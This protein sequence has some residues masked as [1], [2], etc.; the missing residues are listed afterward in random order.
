MT[1]R[2]ARRAVLIAAACLVPAAGG[3]AEYPWHGASKT[4]ILARGDAAP[5]PFAHRIAAFAKDLPADHK[6]KVVIGSFYRGQVGMQQ[7][8][9]SLTPLDS[10]GRP[11]GEELQF[12]PLWGH[13]IHSVTYRKGVKHGPEKAYRDSPRA[14]GRRYVYKLTPWKDGKIHGVVRLSYPTGEAM[15]ET[16]HANGKREGVSRSFEPDGFM[17]RSV[18][19]KNDQRCGEAV[20]YWPTTKKL[21]KVITYKDG[22]SHG[23]ARQ[24]YDSG[25]LKMEVPLWEDEFHGVQKHYDEDGKLRKT[26]YWILDEEVSE[27]QFEKR[28]RVPPIPTTR[29]A[30]TTQKSA[31]TKPVKD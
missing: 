17:K 9:K 7:Q 2:P 1:D 11:D 12:G 20:E 31:E 13:P 26:T 22:L 6:V 4:L 30:P 21:K 18:T 16:P 24:Y 23:P 29:K 15:M 3:L 27:E 5:E 19:Y 14:P 28:F 8:I 10:D 25:K